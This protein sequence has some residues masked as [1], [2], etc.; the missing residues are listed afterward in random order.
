MKTE[1]EIK[2]KLKLFKKGY[3]L[4]PDKTEDSIFDEMELTELKRVEYAGIIW[5]L[6]WVL[7]HET[8]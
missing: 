2:D 6:E 7:S 8:T 4:L 5:I 3:N 1:K